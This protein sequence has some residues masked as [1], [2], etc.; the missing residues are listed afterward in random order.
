LTANEF[1]SIH[2]LRDIEVDLPREFKILGGEKTTEIRD[3]DGA[4][5]W[6]PEA[7]YAK[8]VRD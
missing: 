1:Q 6:A 3:G 2:S 7:K 8:V 4:A 5:Q